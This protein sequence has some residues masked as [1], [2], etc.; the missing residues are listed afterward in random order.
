MAKA[1]QLDPK[2]IAE[3]TYKQFARLL[4]MLEDPKNTAEITI[5]Q[6]INA[7]K[8]LMS[9]DLSAIR[10]NSEQEYAG[11]AL[12]KYARTFEANAASGRAQSA[13]RAATPSL[14]TAYAADDESDDE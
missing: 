5:P 7:L 9:Y 8:A 13:R 10:K 12:S 1:K 6:L 2:R 14:A 4:D 11:S 3:R